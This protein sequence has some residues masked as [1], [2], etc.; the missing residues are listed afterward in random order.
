MARARCD[1]PTGYLLNVYYSHNDA[2]TNTTTPKPKLTQLPLTGFLSRPTPNSTAPAR[3]TPSLPP[4]STDPAST[5]IKAPLRHASVDASAL[6][7]SKRKG[8][9]NPIGIEPKRTKRSATVAPTSPTAVP[10]P[11]ASTSAVS[12][13]AP[14]DNGLGLAVSVSGVPQSS[15]AEFGGTTPKHSSSAESEGARL[16]ALTKSCDVFSRAILGGSTPFDATGRDSMDA[17]MR[18]ARA[19]WL[20]QH[21]A[22]HPDDFASLKLD[23]MRPSHDQHTLDEFKS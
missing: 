3:L 21:A 8:Q 22:C 5:T 23:L 13:V 11:R 20:S 19:Y 14:S 10:P 15:S 1:V 4:A 12:S 16:E 17:M 9:E 7:T 18:A 6:S 2:A